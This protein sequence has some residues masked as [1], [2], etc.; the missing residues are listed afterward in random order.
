MSATGKKLRAR[1]NRRKWKAI[2]KNGRKAGPTHKGRSGRTGSMRSK[3][4]KAANQGS[5]WSGTREGQKPKPARRR[6]AARISRYLLFFSGGRI[7]VVGV[8]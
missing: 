1:K 7:A 5:N 2:R 4:L 3:M 8:Q 6:K